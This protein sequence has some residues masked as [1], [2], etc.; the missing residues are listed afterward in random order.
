V[1]VAARRPAAA[2]QALAVVGV[3]GC[4][5]V[6]LLWLLDDA[7]AAI[8]ADASVRSGIRLGCT[9]S[10][11]T[12]IV[13]PA[14]EAVGTLAVGAAA[15]RGEIRVEAAFRQDGGHQENSQS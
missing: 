11:V 15:R 3:A 14:G 2:A 1:T 7:V 12:D 9:L 5:L 8:L 10:T 4:A 13:V 6:A